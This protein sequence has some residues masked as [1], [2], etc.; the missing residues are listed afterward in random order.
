MIKFRSV[1]ATF[2]ATLMVALLLFSNVAEARPVKSST[3]TS[4]QLEQIQDYVSEL[5]AIRDRLPEL[6]DLIQK[7]NWVFTRNFIHGPLGE[8]RL[9]L[10]TLS[11]A[12]LPKAQAE[13]RKLSNEIFEDLV[14]IDQ[15]AQDRN[16]PAAVRNYAEIVKDF[17]AFL[18]LAPKA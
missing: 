11:R 9:K 17:D 14:A 13:A 8:F 4:E 12:L 2:L 6:A 15:A 18:Q 10:S 16:Y 7:E 5:S 3:Y 1:V